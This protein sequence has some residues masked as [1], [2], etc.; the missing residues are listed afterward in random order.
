MLP[1]IPI[2]TSFSDYETFVIELGRIK[3]L[4]DFLDLFP[5]LK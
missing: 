5:L 1:K 4:W 3:E 2:P